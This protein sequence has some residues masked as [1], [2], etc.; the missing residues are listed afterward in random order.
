MYFFDIRLENLKSYI[1]LNIISIREEH[2][3]AWNCVWIISIWL[4]YLKQYKKR[5]V[6]DLS[7]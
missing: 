4:E 6:D 1:S 3:K 5:K 2:I 7:Q